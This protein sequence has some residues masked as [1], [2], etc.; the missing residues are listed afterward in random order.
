MTEFLFPGPVPPETDSGSGRHTPVLLLR[1]AEPMQSDGVWLSYRS[2]DIHPLLLSIA[3]N[4]PVK[5]HAF[6]LYSRAIGV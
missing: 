5:I 3:Q 6:A 1:G 4:R 2:R